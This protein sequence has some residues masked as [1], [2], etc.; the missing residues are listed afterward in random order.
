M[1]TY[2]PRMAVFAVEKG[3]MAYPSDVV[4]DLLQSFHG[5]RVAIGFNPY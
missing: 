2:L 4:F 5:R 1:M 3:V